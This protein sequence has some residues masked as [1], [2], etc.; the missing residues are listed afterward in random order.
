MSAHEEPEVGRGPE[1]P[2]GASGGPAVPASRTDEPAGWGW[3][4]P[5]LVM[6][7]VVLGLGVF[8]IAGTADVTA[9]GSALG[10]GPRFFPVLV[11]SALLL[12]GVFYVLDVVRGGHGDPEE[13]EDVDSGARADWKT[14]ALLSVIFLAFAGLVD[15]LGWIIAGALLFFGLAVTL[16]AEHRLRAGVIAIVLSTLSYLAFVKGLGVTL[17]AGLLSGVI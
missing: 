10:L 14:V 15:L 17:P 13:S 3:R 6:A 16:G 4:R 2:E 5:E 9:A 1:A 7:L 8:V 12:I 11:G